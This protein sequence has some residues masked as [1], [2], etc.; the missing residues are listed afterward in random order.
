LFAADLVADFIRQLQDLE[1]DEPVLPPRIHAAAESAVQR[2]RYRNRT[3]FA[4]RTGVDATMFTHAARGG[5]S[6]INVAVRVAAMAGVSLAGLMAPRLW[7]ETAIWGPAN[8]FD[9]DVPTRIY[10]C[11][12]D[13]DVI[14][15]EIDAQLKAKYPKAPKQL[16]SALGVYEKHLKRAA[17]EEVKR[18]S[19]AYRAGLRRLR[20]DRARA[21]ADRLVVEADA[22]RSRGLKVSAKKLA[23]RVQLDYTN[24]VFTLAMRKASPKLGARFKDYGRNRILKRHLGA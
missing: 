14:R 16:A 20:D 24:V 4:R 19:K 9:L 1:E 5:L 13:R 10:R 3:E 18:L 2:G 12:C 6:S 11:A 8:V 7:E 17:G 22:L 21:L 23:G 15:K